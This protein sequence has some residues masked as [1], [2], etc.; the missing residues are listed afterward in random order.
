MA[1]PIAADGLSSKMT[2]ADFITAEIKVAQ[3]DVNMLTLAEA[4]VHAR[5][6]AARQRLADLKVVQAA[7][8]T[9]TT[10]KPNG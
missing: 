4:E 2:S 1:F 10:G 5:A 6:Q 3:N 9:P 8:T 7:I